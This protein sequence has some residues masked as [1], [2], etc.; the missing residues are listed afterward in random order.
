MAT[1]TRRAV[2]GDV[3]TRDD[4]S[5]SVP[6]R[7]RFLAA[8]RPL[9]AAVGGSIVN[10]ARMRAGD[11]PV[12]WDGALV[13]ALR[14]PDLRTALSRLILQVEREFGGRL[15]ELSR[16]DKQRAIAMLDERGA[17]ELRRA[18]EDVADAMSVSRVTVYSYL[19]AISRR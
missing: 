9:A 4:A 8:I 15:D 2:A 3:D 10:P 6:D 1:T 19:D 13:G 14:L 7:A 17:F 18:V 12:H 5:A 11:V 16:E